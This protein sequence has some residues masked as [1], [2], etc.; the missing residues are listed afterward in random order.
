MLILLE[1]T[2]GDKFQ[3]TATELI[4]LANNN[5]YGRFYHSQTSTDLQWE[6]GLNDIT[7]LQSLSLPSSFAFRSNSSLFCF[8]LA[9]FFFGP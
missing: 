4:T 1:S 6:V 3:L 5:G 8:S 2:T 7:T 9:S